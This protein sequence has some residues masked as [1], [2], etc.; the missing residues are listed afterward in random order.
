MSVRVKLINS[1]TFWFSYLVQSLYLVLLKL[2]WLSHEKNIKYSQQLI[3]LQANVTD[4]AKSEIFH[5]LFAMFASNCSSLSLPVIVQ[6]NMR[7]QCHIFLNSKSN[8]TLTKAHFI[9]RKAYVF[10]AHEGDV[11]KCL[12]ANCRQFMMTYKWRPK[13]TVK[14]IFRW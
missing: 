14:H 13:L 5:L 11:T 9:K 12:L 6:A 3:Q 7:I 4:A 2:P 8:N 10:L 1:T